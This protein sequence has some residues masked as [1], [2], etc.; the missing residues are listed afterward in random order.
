MHS[1]SKGTS[2]ARL[3]QRVYNLS[4]VMLYL[5]G[6]IVFAFF[7][8]PFKFLE[9]LKSLAKEELMAADW[10]SANHEER[11]KTSFIQLLITGPNPHR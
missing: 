5:L 6:D 2:A 4:P 11:K 8:Q 3:W 1:P 10:A 7:S 9:A